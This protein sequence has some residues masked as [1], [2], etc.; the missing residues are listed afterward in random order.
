MTERDAFPKSDTAKREEDTLA[1]WKKRRIF[2][3]TLAKHSPE[4]NFV[5]YEGPPTANGRPGLHHLISRIFKDAIPRYKTM[6]G[7]YVPRRGG[8]D[9]HGLPVEIEVE[10]QLGFT[11]KKQIEE[12]GIEKFNEKCKESAWKY[13]D[14]WREF[15]ERMGYWID[16]DNAY[17]TYYP[18]YIEALWAI[19]QHVDKRK[20]LYKDYKVLPWC[21]RCG[22]AL[23][24]HELAQGY[25]DV[26]DTSV[27]VK[28]KVKGEENTYLLAWTTTPWTLPGNVGLAVKEDILYVKVEDDK[29]TFWVAKDRA[30]VLFPEAKPVEEKKGKDLI[31]LSYEPLFPFLQK[32]LPEAEKSKLE[33]AYKVYAADFVGAEDGT[34]IVHTAVMY[35]QDD[36]ELGTKVGL[37]K[38][39]LVGEDGTFTKD[40]GPYAGLLVTDKKTNKQ[41]IEDLGSLIF[42][43]EEVTHT[44][45]FCW[46]CKTPLIYF[47]RNSWYIAMSKLRDELVKENEKIN[48]VPEHIKDGRFGEWLKEVKDW[49]I[50]RDRYWGTPLPIWECEG[51]DLH[52]VVGS[53]GEL[54][55]EEHL[56]ENTYTVMRHGESVSYA[57]NIMS[58]D[59]GDAEDLLTEKGKGEALESAKK[60][61][62]QKID[63]I[64]V[65]PF[66]RTLETAAIVAEEV[67]LSEKE[68]IVDERIREIKAGTFDGRS[69]YE[70]GLLFQGEGWSAKRP[71]GGESH[72]DIILRVGEFIYDIEKKY[73]GKNILIITHAAPA[74]MLSAVAAGAGENDLAKHTALFNETA[75]WHEISF[76]PH[77]H[78]PE[79]ELDLH[80][81]YIDEVLLKCEKC[82]GVM[83][84]TPEVMDVWFDSGA[85]PFAQDAVRKRSDT[86]QKHI[87]YTPNFKHALF[88]ADFVSEAVD[89]T[90]GW[91]YTLH[92]IGI[93]MD[94]GRAFNNVVC[95]GHILDA[96]GKKMSKSIGNVVNPWEMF[97]K[98]GVDVL[99]FWMYSINQPGDT[100]NFDEKTVAEVNNKVFTLLRNIVKFYKLHLSDL[101][102]TTDNQQPENQHVLDEWLRALTGTLVSEVTLRMDTYD[103]FGATRAIRDF[104]NDFST[105][106]IRRSRDRFKMNNED[107]EAALVATQETLLTLAK[108]L[109]PVTPFFAEEVYADI[110]G[111]HESVHL[112]EWPEANVSRHDG[113]ILDEM[114]EVRDVVSRALEAR[115]SAGIKIRQPLQKLTLRATYK[116][117]QGKDALLDLIK[118][119]LNVKEVVFDESAGWDLELDTN[120]TPELKKEGD[121]RDLIRAIQDFRKQ[122]GLTPADKVSVRVVTDEKGKDLIQSYKANILLAATLSDISVEVSP[123][124][125]EGDK[126][127]FVF[128]LV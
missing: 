47:A 41:I 120:I 109:A 93:L 81:P 104:I 74:Q 60:I 91:F 26:T 11:S 20:L 125:A 100:K 66:R 97:A 70:F 113:R 112:E 54:F 44:Y 27:Y 48:W 63:L 10:K 37:P 32:S 19:V 85:M 28:F 43:T 65:S 118:D 75:E 115:A 86:S 114:K 83:R 105:W 67:G 36:F 96:K 78:N 25:A 98:H 23:S 61:K 22:T 9:T 71:E 128:S 17:V 6:R 42:K 123:D 64:L 4:G 52:R 62:K 5:F 72:K 59:V 102:P 24:S 56:S 90:R 14:E 49:A 73:S 40:A 122:S 95:L 8:W 77:P 126:S 68:I 116:N 29:E 35:G 84:R 94:R 2:E 99:R 1:R 18:A 55:E 127:A 106:Y 53:I 38:H 76:V 121:L 13:I 57:Q 103:L 110:K 16:L 111:G 92:A 82:D 88:P 89:Q 107:R 117:L 31:G 119:E 21:T 15:T 87:E 58:T 33:N 79:F 30:G 101:Q 7:Y 50:S 51:C 46:R 12:Y 34:G 3:K 69:M 39:H 124:A 45:P 80:K 108:L